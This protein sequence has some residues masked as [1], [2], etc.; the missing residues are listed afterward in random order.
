MANTDAQ[1]GKAQVE[2]AEVITPRATT[3][4]NTHL[5]ELHGAVII[6]D[7]R[8]EYVVLM[9]HTVERSERAQSGPV[10][11]HSAR[12]HSGKEDRH[13]LPRKSP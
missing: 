3:A 12:S 5:D 4:S 13:G 2:P 9:A 10:N 8:R 7:C 1:S 11:Y 6:N